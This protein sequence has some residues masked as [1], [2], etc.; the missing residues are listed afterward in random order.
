MTNGNPKIPV[1]RDTF[2]Q[3]LRTVASSVAVIT[4]CHE[5]HLHGMT[6]TAF[7]SVSADPPTILIVVNRSTRSYPLISGS[8]AF[9]VNFL[10]QEQRHV[11]DLFAG[12]ATNQFASVAYTTGRNDAPIIDG[13]AAHLDCETLSETACETHTVFLARVVAASARQSAPLLYH[14]GNYRRI[15]HEVQL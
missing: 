11:S 2:C 9:V 13:A 14:N 12:K 3:A 1:D 7:S 6:A 5:G 10:S 4:T 15:D 8:R